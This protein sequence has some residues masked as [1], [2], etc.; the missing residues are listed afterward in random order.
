VCLSNAPNQCMDWPAAC[1]GDHSCDC[2][3]KQFG[4]DCA[5]SRCG[6]NNAVYE[7]L[8]INC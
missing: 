3:L 6:V 2:L 1:S 5:P 8:I 4:S 7:L